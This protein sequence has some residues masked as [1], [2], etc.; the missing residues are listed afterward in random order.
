MKRILQYVWKYKGSLIFGTVSMLI[1]IGIDLFSPYLQKVFLDK[2]IIGGE[3]S[4]II[5]ILI[6]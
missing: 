4:L 3:E 6:C 5:P 1:I 2:G